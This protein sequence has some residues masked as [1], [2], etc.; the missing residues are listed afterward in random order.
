MATV[1]IRFDT[2]E[3]ERL[4]VDFSQAPGRIQRKA[5]KVMRKTALEIKSGMRRDLLAGMHNHGRTHIPDMSG[6]I[7]YDQLDAIGL[8]YEIG[9]DKDG[10]QGEL[11]NFA[12]FGSPINNAPIFDHTDSMRRE[13]P[14]LLRALGAVAEDSVFGG[15]K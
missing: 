2:S 13:M 1:R 10:G 12:A 14:R 8:A 4:A 15:L 11:G 3:L 6:A 5:P 9:I 7:N